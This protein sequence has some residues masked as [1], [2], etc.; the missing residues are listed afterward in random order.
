MDTG[1]DLDASQKDFLWPQD[2]RKK[3]TEA[4]VKFLFLIQLQDVESP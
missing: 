1:P 3:S 4:A 2:R